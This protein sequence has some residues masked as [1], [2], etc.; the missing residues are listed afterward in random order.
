MQLEV[1]TLQF[2]YS[3]LFVIITR[4]IMITAA[5][6]EPNLPMPHRHARH[7]DQLLLL[8]RRPGGGARPRSVSGPRQRQRGLREELRVQRRIRAHL[9]E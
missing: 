5:N 7:S 4:P 8:P 1:Q 9:Q 6:D 2:G 3:F